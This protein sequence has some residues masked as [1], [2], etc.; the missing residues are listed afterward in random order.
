MESDHEIRS[1]M[2]RALGAPSLCPSGTLDNPTVVHG[3]VPIVEFR[4]LAAWTDMS[5]LMAEIDSMS[6]MYANV[7]ELGEDVPLVVWKALR[8]SADEPMLIARLRSN[9]DEIEK[10]RE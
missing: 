3:K 8:H 1:A 5:A 10:S 6:K 4:A 7:L 9:L 2:E